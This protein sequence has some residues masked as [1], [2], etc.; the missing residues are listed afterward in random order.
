MLTTIV[1]P[2]PFFGASVDMNHVGGDLYV[3]VGDSS[4]SSVHVFQD[5]T[6][7]IVST[8]VG[9]QPTFRWH[10]TRTAADSD[11]FGATVALS[12]GM[13]AV[14]GNDSTFL[15]AI[16]AQGDGTYNFFNTDLSTAKMDN[17]GTALQVAGQGAVTYVNAGAGV[18][19]PEGTWM[20]H[21]DNKL[22]TKLAHQ[23]WRLQRSG[24]ELRQLQPSP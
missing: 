15:N 14:G 18:Y 24:C 10:S 23:H 20:V 17:A 4:N 13:F 7:S 11:M 16:T 3:T 12:D 19:G 6:K 1:T 22:I 21:M 5:R 8:V 2:S 9:M